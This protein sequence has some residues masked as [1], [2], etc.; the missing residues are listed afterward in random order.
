MDDRDLTGT[1]FNIQKFSVHD[2]PGIRT[3]VFMKGCPLRCRWC[4]NAESMNPEPEIG[5][6]KA[7]CDLC[8]E[9]SS[10][11][12]RQAITVTENEVKINR[13]ECNACGTCVEV[14]PCDALTVYGRNVS[15]QDV[16][17]EVYKDMRFFSG[18]AG[19]VTV[20]G[21]EPLRQPDFVVALLRKCKEKGIHTCLDTTGYATRNDFEKV[22]MYADMVLFDL[23][24]MDSASHRQYTGVPNEQ[25]KENAIFAAS[26]EKD[27]LFRIPLIETV[28]SDRRNIEATAEFISSFGEKKPVE[29]L[30]YHKLGIAKYGTLGR[31]YQ[32]STLRTP[33]EQEID[34]CRK[35]FENYG[36]EC[37]I[38]G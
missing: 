30:P 24:M 32:G 38:G 37:H 12:Q 3:T 16:F 17:D 22:L 10:A 4:S 19:G 6:L 18:S 31:E 27:I 8:G 7:L 34:Y 9:C 21:G 20:S 11:C 1:I 14:C 26:K 5:Y 28:N 35:I 2:G 25:I 29:L 15:V 13:D 36:I 33:S 23:K